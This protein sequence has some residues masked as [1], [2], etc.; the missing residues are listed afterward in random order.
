[1]PTALITGASS[2]I[3]RATAR[4][5]AKRGNNLVLLARR[6]KKLRRLAESIKCASNVEVDVLVGD[7]CSVQ[8]SNEIASKVTLLVNNAGVAL[9]REFAHASSVADWNT[10]MRTNCEGTF[11]ITKRVLHSMRE[12]Q[13]GHI[14]FIGSIAGIESYEGGSVYCA[15]KHAIHAFARALRYETHATPIKVSV[16]APGLVDKGTEFSTVRF[17]GDRERARNEYANMHALSASNVASV[18]E[19]ICTQPKHVCVDFVQLMPQCQGSAVRIHRDAACEKMHAM[20]KA[21]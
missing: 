8:L 15:S 19:W 12:Q 16:I 4:L 1:M 6:Q 18:V 17:C 10:M 14:V 2:G 3:G 9:G 20:E 21:R 7:I 13:R 5:L 11:S